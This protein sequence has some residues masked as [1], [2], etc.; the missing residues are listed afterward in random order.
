MHGHSSADREADLT[1]NGN[2]LYEVGIPLTLSHGHLLDFEHRN[3][4]DHGAAC[5]EWQGRRVT[6]RTG[7]VVS[8]S[9]LCLQANEIQRYA[10]KCAPLNRED[11]WLEVYCFHA[12]RFA[13]ARMVEHCQNRLAFAEADL[14]RTRRDSYHYAEVVEQRQRE[15]GAAEDLVF[16]LWYEEAAPG[17]AVAA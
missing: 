7:H 2:D 8:L 13:S 16:D 14:R 11:A 4:A 9:L 12:A 5:R 10:D 6:L 15:L 1:L 17:S 3:D